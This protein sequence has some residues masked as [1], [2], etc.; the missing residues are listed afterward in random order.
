MN[1]AASNSVMSVSRSRYGRRIK[2]S[3]YRALASMK[4]IAEIASF[5]KSKTHYGE[6]LSGISEST[7]HRANL[8]SMLR[9]AYF[10]NVFDLCR[11]ERSIGSGV[12]N[13]IFDRHEFR[14]F[15][16]YLICF[17]SGNPSKF[18]IDLP[19]SLNR[20]SEID[21]EKLS[22]ISD[23][24]EL[25][26]CIAGTKLALIAGDIRAGDKI[27][28]IAIESKLRRTLVENAL[29]NIKKGNV[30][31]DSEELK[32]LVLLQS[33]LNDFILLYRAK[34][35][36]GSTPL[37]I[38]SLIVGK[39]CFIPKKTFEKM[40]NAETAEKAVELF[41]STK[42][43]KEA[44]EPLTSENINAFCKKFL[45]SYT[46]RL[47]HFS[48]DP[49]VVTLSYILYSETE[50]N[51]LINIIEGVRYELSPGEIEKEITVISK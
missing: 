9:T 19:M 6:S 37:E 5:L 21:F 36:Y 3:D 50:L 1:Q 46:T 26:D 49:A 7:I 11:F 24:N 22:S 10:N 41:M 43:G 29:S 30:K 31:G 13:Y 2:E 44:T 42:Y 51:N 15:L 33:E 48:V 40:V 38:S 27:E 12:F 23:K 32:K 8:E 35:Y 4:T 28:L 45:L 20:H 34:K 14:L 47:I 39:Q 16:S 17:I 25:A 18:L